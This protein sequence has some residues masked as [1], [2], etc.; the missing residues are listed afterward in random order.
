M[1]GV[2]NKGGLSSYLGSSKKISYC[3]SV[4]F[5][6][7]SGTN[8]GTGGY[9][10]SVAISTYCY[11][12]SGNSVPAKQ[13]LLQRPGKTIMF[14]DHASVDSNGSFNEQID[15]FAPIYLTRDEDAGWGGATPTMHFRHNG[16]TNVCW[17]DG[18][19]SGEGPLTLAQSG[20]GRTAAA[21][22]GTFNIGWFGGNDADAIADLFR[23]RKKGKL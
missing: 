6:Y 23:C 13:S 11:G 1:S 17:A 10:Y 4:Q 21:L 3:A 19:V 16:R 7:N 12:D 2:E 5:V 18:H 20:W 8:S 15:L 22:S 14:A 9:G